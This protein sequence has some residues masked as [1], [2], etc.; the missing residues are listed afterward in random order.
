MMALA[1]K[2]GRRPSLAERSADQAMDVAESELT[3]G[4]PAFQ[5]ALMTGLFVERNRFEE[6]E[7]ARRVI[8]SNLR[9]RGLTAQR[10][11]YIAERALQHFQPGGKLFPGLDEPT[12]FL[13]EALPLLPA[14]S[15]PVLPVEDSI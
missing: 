5:I 14:P 1:E 4:K 9:A 11:F 3:F 13:E 2:T 12:L 10:L 6:A 8:E 15:R 7:A